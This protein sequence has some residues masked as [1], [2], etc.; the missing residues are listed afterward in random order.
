MAAPSPRGALTPADLENLPPAQRARLLERN[1]ELAE[2]LRED[3]P[4]E[5][6][7]ARKLAPVPDPPS[8]PA[9]QRSSGRRRGSTK[10]AKPAAKDRPGSRRGGAGRRKSS[11]RRLASRVV[12]ETPGVPGPSVTNLVLSFAGTTILVI[13]LV[14]L[15]DGGNQLQRL[16]SWLG[17]AAA[18]L[19]DPADPI[20]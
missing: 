10:A 11:G 3:P 8:E 12:R 4:A 6:A 15:I 7:P 20:F 9:E 19:T 14:V 2:A 17:S 1:P 13:G 5:S 16:P 18:K